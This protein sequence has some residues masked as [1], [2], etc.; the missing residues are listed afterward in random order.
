MTTALNPSTHIITLKDNSTTH[1]HLRGLLRQQQH[2]IQKWTQFCASVFAYKPS[3]P[4]PEYFA[5]HF[6]NDPRCDASLVRVMIH[7]P[8]AAN[9]DEAQKMTGEIV[10]S[11]RIFRRTL[12][13]GSSNSG[14]ATI[15]AG[16]I[17]EVCTSPDHQ[18]RGLSKILLKDAINIMST[19]CDGVGDSGGMMSCSLLHANPEFRPVYNKVGGYEC[20]PSKWSLVPIK[21]NKLVINSS[22]DETN[23]WTTRQ[24][25]FPQDVSQLKALHTE[26]SEKRLITITR[27]T[28]YWTNY[29]SAELGE[30]LW[31]LED[32]ASIV[33][34]LSIRKR[35][36]RYQLRE[37]G[38]DR[39]K[40]S[41]S[42]IISFA[43][44]RLLGVALQQIGEDVHVDSE[45]KVSLLLP[46]FILSDMQQEKMNGANNEVGS[47]HEDDYS[48][49]DNDS[50]VEEND[51]G[52]MYVVFDKSEPNV[53]ELTMRAKD[54]VPHLIWP[55]DSF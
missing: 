1:Y 47:N 27:S 29:V 46:T 49:F 9:D 31:V 20:V 6:Y 5:R 4:P 8:N 17:G 28:E 42:N 24:A 53:L 14:G 51:D 32:D 2:D 50:V 13:I 44:K 52:W 16:G 12:S 15:E 3:P 36:D 43:L 7:C 23:K 45:K 11:V 54:P 33:A 55:T 22:T 10:S 48:L 21:L 40:H 39:N 25:I 38:A 37:F 34:W 30:S 19:S 26:Y 35:G 41:I 18:R